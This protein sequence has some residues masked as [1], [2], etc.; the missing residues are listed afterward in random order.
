[1]IIC[2]YKSY[3]LVLSR[4]AS[5]YARVSFY[6]KKLSFSS[7][8]HVL[9]CRFF[10]QSISDQFIIWKY[11][12]SLRRL[13]L[14]FNSKSFFWK[15]LLPIALIRNRSLSRRTGFQIPVNVIGEGVC[16][17]HYG[18]II[19]NQDSCVGKNCTI[20]PGIVIGHKCSG[21]PSPIIG[22]NVTINS[23]ARI[24][25]G[26]RI[27]NDVIIAPNA[28]VT[29]DIPSHCIVAG[30]PARIIKFRS[31]IGSDWIDYH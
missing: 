31:N 7:I 23:G 6:N 19:I 28:V 25:G 11:I 26:I 17:Y 29:H 18:T 10:S 30:V 13:E 21:D 12:R 8:L 9:R 15:L 16:I 5:S 4:D 3:R 14:C 20:R 22:D 24:I 1:M 2:D 27:G